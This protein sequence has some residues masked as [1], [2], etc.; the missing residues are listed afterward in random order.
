MAIAGKCSG[1]QGFD[2]YLL[3]LVPVLVLLQPT[4]CYY[5]VYS[6]LYRLTGK[7]CLPKFDNLPTVKW[8]IIFSS[9]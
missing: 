5:A 1:L 2:L 9:I 7:S 8:G 4:P 6:K 3:C